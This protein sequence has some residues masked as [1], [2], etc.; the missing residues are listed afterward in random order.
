LHL[1]QIYIIVTELFT[2]VQ[3]KSSA[4]FACGSENVVQYRPVMANFL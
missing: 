2:V 3:A 4:L 1:K